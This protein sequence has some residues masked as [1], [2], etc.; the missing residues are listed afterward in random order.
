MK[1]GVFNAEY[2]SLSPQREALV[3][4]ALPNRVI[5]PAF[6]GEIVSQSF[7][8]TLMWFSLS[9]QCEGVTPPVFNSPPSSPTQRELSPFVVVDSVSVGGHSSRY[10]CVDVLKQNLPETK[11]VCTCLVTQPCLTA[12]EP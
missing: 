10:L 7:L 9:A 6:H 1:V 3:L 5:T 11:R 4:S 2:S 8:S 12:S